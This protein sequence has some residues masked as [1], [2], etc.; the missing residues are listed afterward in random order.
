MNSAYI[1]FG[2][3][4]HYR[5]FSVLHL[6]AF[7]YIPYRDAP[8]VFSRPK[9]LGH[10]LNPRETLVELGDGLIYMWHMMRGREAEDAEGMRVRRRGDLETALGKTRH[11]NARRGESWYQSRSNDKDLSLAANSEKPVMGIPDHWLVSALGDYKPVRQ[12]GHQREGDWE[13]DNDIWDAE[14][15]SAEHTPLTTRSEYL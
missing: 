11:Y 8:P 15:E 10:A 13:D 9:A 5:L 12:G 2:F 6:K 4:R 1:V 3:L 7:T 14:L